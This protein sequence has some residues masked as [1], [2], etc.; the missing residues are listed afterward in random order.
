MSRIPLWALL[1]AA[2]AVSCIERNNPFDPIHSGPLIREALL[3]EYAPA[4]DSLLEV[5]A[6]LG[7]ALETFRGAF[8][9]D[10]ARREGILRLNVAIREA[11]A[12]Q[13]DSNAAIETRNRTRPADSLEEKSFRGF[14]QALNPIAPPGFEDW[15]PRRL[16]AAQATLAFIAGVNGRHHPVRVYL[17]DLSDSLQAA[18]SRDSLQYIRLR[19]GI[20]EYNRQL[21]AWNLGVA[22]FNQTAAEENTRIAGY[23]DSVRFKRLLGSRQ[24]IVL[25]DSLG[26]RLAVARPGDTLTLAP[27]IFPID[28]NI[29][30]SG[31]PEKPILIAGFPGRRTILIPALRRDGPGNQAL[32]VSRKGYLRFQ[33]LVFR[34]GRESAVRIVDQSAGVVFERCVFDSSQGAGLVALDS[35]LDL[36]DC[37][38][39]ANG[40]AGIVLGGAPTTG[41]KLRLTHVLSVG[42]GGPGLATTSQHLTVRNGTFAHNGGDGVR[43]DSPLQPLVILN[44]IIAGNRGHGISRQATIIHPEFLEVGGSVVHGNVLGDWNLP[45]LDSAHAARLRAATLDADPEFRDPAALDYHPKPGS[46]VDLLEKQALPVVIGYREGLR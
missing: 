10:S 30:Q 3:R 25:A 24:P 36:I 13:M 12:R 26:A 37:I 14:Q 43:V 28:F 33:D 35:E 21:A 34:G 11:S 45:K 41:F 39:T 27:G 9:A 42:N 1:P 38:A 5:E 4:L 29:S 20:S 15:L 16:S 40:E 18:C 17:P 8:Q 6:A 22:A 2:L 44:S 31:T 7:R 23:N 19:H 46:P 32:M